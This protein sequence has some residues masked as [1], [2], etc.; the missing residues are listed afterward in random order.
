[1]AEA[2]LEQKLKTSKLFPL[3]DAPSLWFQN[4]KEINPNQKSEE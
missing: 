3:A 1:M 4:Y 2:K